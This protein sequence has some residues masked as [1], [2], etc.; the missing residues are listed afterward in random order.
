M[1]KQ[2]SIF[3]MSIFSLLFA[4]EEGDYINRIDQEK[5]FDV[6]FGSTDEY[7]KLSNYNGD[8]NGGMYHVIHID[9]AASW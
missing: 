2:L 9:M 1:T 8:F 7:F 6:C 3:T 5:E 4:Y